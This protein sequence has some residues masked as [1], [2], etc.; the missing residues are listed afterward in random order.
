MAKIEKCHL[1]LLVKLSHICQYM[2]LL[3]IIMI[4]IYL[5]NPV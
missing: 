5:Y 1:Y 2:Y 4:E 3:Y